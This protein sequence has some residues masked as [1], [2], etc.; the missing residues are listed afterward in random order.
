MTS[1]E[2]IDRTKR[3]LNAGQDQP[4]NWAEN[5]IELAASVLQ[6]IG[7]LSHRVMRD[8]S[9][10]PLLQQLYAVSLSPAG[11]GDLLLATGSITGN[12]GEI[13][14][15]G[16][17]LGVVRDADNNILVPLVHYSDFLRPLPTVY[18]YYCLKDR[19]IATRAIGVAVS[20][21]ADIQSVNSPLTI[22]A[23]FSPREVDDFPPELHDLLVF[24]LCDVVTRKTSLQ[25]A[26]AQ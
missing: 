14:M 23:S 5:E 26:N 6:A 4:R 19:V 20:S 9:L 22:T 17:H 10:R 16:I 1:A 11:E 3:Q 12:A 21:P 7:E 15:E 18:G 25:N 2:L 13:L 8:S 24:A